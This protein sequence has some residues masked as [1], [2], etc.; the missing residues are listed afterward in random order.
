MSGLVVFSSDVNRLANFYEA[1]L[2]AER[3]AEVSGD[4]RL[5]TPDAEVLVHS[6]PK[7]AAD[8]I[9]ITTPPEP[10]D[11]SPMKP[12]F[13]VGSLE[14]AVEAVEAAGGVV[15]DRTFSFAGLTRHDVLDP[16]GNVIQL[17]GRSS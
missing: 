5:T 9:V 15:T 2:G 16:D 8:R 11:A 14:R 10:R 12:I 4:V 3:N 7:R 6:I 17:R 13:D 1:V